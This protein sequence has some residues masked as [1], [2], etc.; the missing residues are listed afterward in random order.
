MLETK[1]LYKYPPPPKKKIIIII[2]VEYTD[3]KTGAP[4]K[5]GLACLGRKFV[6]ENWWRV[7][8]P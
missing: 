2:W 4:M 3:T 6:K 7:G 8:A 5:D 1:A